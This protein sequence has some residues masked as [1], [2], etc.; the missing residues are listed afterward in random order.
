MKELIVFGLIAWMLSA[1][2]ATQA[3]GKRDT[4][5]LPVQSTTSGVDADYVHGDWCVDGR[6]F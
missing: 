2:A 3:Y 1:M 5:E 4:A 6:S